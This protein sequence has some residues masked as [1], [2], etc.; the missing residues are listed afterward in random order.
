M[1]NNKI[2]KKQ[3]FDLNLQING[4]EK[5]QKW[6]YGECL[7]LAAALIAYDLQP[8]KSHLEELLEELAD[9]KVLLHQYCRYHKIYNSKDLAFKRT[10]TEN[11]IIELADSFASHGLLVAYGAN[12]HSAIVLMQNIKIC[13]KIKPDSKP[14]I[15]D[16]YLKKV[17]NLYRRLLSG[18]FN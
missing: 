11:N 8:T 16:Y 7:E 1:K 4:K 15:A 2:T 5:L 18:E 12:V 6:L 3:I 14:R 17:K 9:V 13:E 10:L